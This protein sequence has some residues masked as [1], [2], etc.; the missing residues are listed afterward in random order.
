[1]IDRGSFIETIPKSTYLSLCIQCGYEMMLED[2]NDNDKKPLV[3][4]ARKRKD[5]IPKTFTLPIDVVDTL[6][7]FSH[8]LDVKKSH[9]VRCCILDFER[10]ESEKLSQQ[11]EELMRE[12]AKIK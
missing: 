10:K 2:Y 8:K 4:I 7:W 11:I 3:G 5:T 9:L 6:S 1:M 12:S